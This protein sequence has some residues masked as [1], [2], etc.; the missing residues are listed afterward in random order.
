MTF[1]LW[2]CTGAQLQAGRRTLLLE[3]SRWQGLHGAAADRAGWAGGRAGGQMRT[4]AHMPARTRLPFAPLRACALLLV[5]CSGPCSGH[6][7]AQRGKGA[8]ATRAVGDS[9]TNSLAQRLPERVAIELHHAA[10]RSSVRGTPRRQGPTTPE[11]NASR[12]EA[13]EHRGMQ[14]FF[15]FSKPLMRTPQW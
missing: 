9:G 1:R 6:L 14:F 7:G 5:Q 11:F 13:H 10:G 15:L 2:T 4:R 8:G 3:Q 12:F